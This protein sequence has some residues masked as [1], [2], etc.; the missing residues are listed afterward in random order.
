MAK[1]RV[2]KS[3]KVNI[4]KILRVLKEAQTEGEDF[5]TINKIAKRTGNHKWSVSRIVDL[6][7]PYVNARAIAELDAIGLQAKLVELSE[8]T[9]TDQQAMRYLSVRI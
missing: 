8:P 3:T 6:Y 7:M 2:T 1:G 9:I 4:L 5:L